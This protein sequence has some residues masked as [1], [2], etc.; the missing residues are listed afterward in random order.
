MLFF[1]WWGLPD[2]LKFQSTMFHQN[3]GW[4]ITWHSYGRHLRHRLK[5]DLWW[6]FVC[7]LFYT[8]MDTHP[9]TSVV[10]VLW[11]NFDGSHRLGHHQSMCSLHESHALFN[12]PIAGL[13]EIP[14]PDMLA[15]EWC[16]YVHYW[17]LNFKNK[18]NVT[19]SPNVFDIN[20]WFRCHSWRGRWMRILWI[21]P[22]VS[23]VKIS[24]SQLSKILCG[25]QFPHK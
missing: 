7:F 15:M 14:F 12:A 21:I 9:L 10:R 22:M 3:Y 24:G 16:L 23:H 11:G 20:M 2:I 5:S 17:T 4:I 18:H 13:L 25:T 19:Q 6:F 8:A 1:T